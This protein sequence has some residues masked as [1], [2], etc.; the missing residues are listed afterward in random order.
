MINDKLGGGGRRQSLFDIVTWQ[1]GKAF[2][3]RDSR[4][5]LSPEHKSPTS[6]NMPRSN[7]VD[8]QRFVIDRKEH[9]QPVSSSLKSIP[10]TEPSEDGNKQ[11]SN[12]GTNAYER[13]S[14]QA[15]QARS[16]RVGSV[17]FGGESPQDKTNRTRFRLLFSMLLAN[18]IIIFVSSK[19]ELTCWS[20]VFAF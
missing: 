20:M 9:F 10:R 16:W 6:P 5:S 1:I 7:E 2:Q 3:R 18:L 14:S 17:C 11:S 15:T 4:S 13:Q 12:V 19:P 8:L